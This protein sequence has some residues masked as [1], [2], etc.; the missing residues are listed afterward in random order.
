MTRKKIAILTQPLHDNYGGLLQAY[1]LSKYVSRFGEVLIIN[2]WGGDKSKPRILA[3]KLKRKFEKKTCIPTKQQREI[4]SQHTRSFQK[5]YIPH[6]SKKIITNAGMKELN[7][8]G[9]DTYIVGSDQCWRPRYS[10]NIT[11]FFLDFVED[12][13]PVTRISYAASFGTSDWEFDPKQTKICRQLIQKF[14]A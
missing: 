3:S 4:I 9:F 6:L 5:K 2:R 13:H 1:A 12:H 8:S 10:P 14:D 7:K 11:N